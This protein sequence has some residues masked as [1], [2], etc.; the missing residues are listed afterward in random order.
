MLLGDIVRLNAQK[1]PN[2]TAWGG[3]GLVLMANSE[4]L[5]EV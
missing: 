5:G 4:L 2:R 1:T 3:L